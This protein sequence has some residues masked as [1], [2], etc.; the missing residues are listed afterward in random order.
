MSSG[1]KWLDEGKEMLDQVEAWAENSK[2]IFENKLILLEAEYYASMCN[3][4]AAKESYELAIKVARDNGYIH[5]QGLAYGECYCTHT[6]DITINMCLSHQVLINHMI[7][8]IHGSNN[9]M[10]GKIFDINR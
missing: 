8:F 1:D 4:V 2:P 6:Y 7:T 3:V 5:E 9:R 10:H